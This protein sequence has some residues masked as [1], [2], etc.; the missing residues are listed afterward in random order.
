[1]PILVKYFGWVEKILEFNHGVLK[2][3]VL[4]LNWVKEN[5][6]NNATME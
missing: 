1:M 4:L 2:I 6:N 5:N 3:V